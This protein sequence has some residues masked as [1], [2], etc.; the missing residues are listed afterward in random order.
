MNSKLFDF[1]IYKNKLRSFCFFSAN[2][3]NVNKEL[4]NGS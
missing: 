2:I 3:D 4:K 1:E